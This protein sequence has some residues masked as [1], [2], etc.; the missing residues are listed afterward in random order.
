MARLLFILLL[1]PLFAHADDLDVRIRKQMQEERV[2]GLTF[3]VVQ[4]GK[5][6]RLGAYGLANLEWHAQATNDTRFEVA[7]VSKMVAGAAIRLLIE[8]GK[9]DPEAPVSHY[10]EALPASWSA[11]K[12]R[13]LI[14]MSSGF[15]E[16]FGSAAIPYNAEVCTPTDEASLIKV[17]ETLPMKPIGDRFSY[18]SVN[19]AMLG[20]IVAKVSGKTYPQF[21]QERVFTPAGMTQSS[22]IDN[23]AIVPQ[24][25]E[26][27]RRAKGDLKRGWFLGQYL[28]SRPDDAVLTTS[29]DLAKFVI[30]LEQKLIVKR[31]EEMWS[32][33]KSDTGHFL[34]YAY[35]WNDHT[36]LGHRRFEHAGGYRTGFHTFVAEY[37][38]DA[39]TV[40]VLTNC[41]FSAV[42]EYVNMIT[43]AYLQ[44]APD[45]ATQAKTTD[46]DPRTTDRLIA[47]LNGIAKGSLDP[48][49]IYADAIEPLGL[50]EAS[51]FL[52]HAAPFHYAG[53]GRA[54]LTMHAHNLVDYE[55]LRTEIDGRALLLTLYR[56]ASGKVAHIELTN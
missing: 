48:N 39:L 10:L 40:V 26:G 50:D 22:V 23:S 3:A 44:G 17:F 49:L 9:V 31:P 38:D 27:Y 54:Q 24:R 43:F 29:R 25:A 4:Q 35:G 14:T 8:E 16:D 46:S 2:P 5:I 19:Y 33:P 1:L 55:T 12:V 41:D 7:S 52:A 20:M 13:H 47:V 51:E 6:A 30:A 45:P 42:R 56:D 18:S 11:M 36:W 15:P 34:D 21:L 32:F 53:R 37:P 28:H